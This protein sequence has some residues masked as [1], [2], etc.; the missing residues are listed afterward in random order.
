MKDHL[1]LSLLLVL[2][3]TASIVVS[4]LP[5]ATAAGRLEAPDWRMLLRELAKELVEKVVDWCAVDDPEQ[6]RTV[7]EA[8]SY[9]Y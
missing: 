6:M 7:A 3:L 5:P 4:D 8:G 2:M 9:Q 1:E